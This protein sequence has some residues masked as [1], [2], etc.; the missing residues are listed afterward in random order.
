VLLKDFDFELPKSSIALRPASPRDASRLLVID[1]GALDPFFDAQVRDLPRFLKAGDVMVFN[2]TKVLPAELNGFREPR[3]E[4]QAV[5][6]CLTLVEPLHN[7]EWKAL[8]R[9]ARRLR[10]GDLIVFEKDGDR[11]VIA[12]TKKS[13]EG[14]VFVKAGSGGTVE[15]IMEQH[16]VMPLPPYISRLRPAD[17]RDLADYQTFYAKSKGAIAAP[18]AGLHFTPHLMGRIAAQGVLTA[19]VTLHVGPGTFL[20]VKSEEIE[21]H[22]LHAEWCEVSEMSARTINECRSKGGR[23]IA[24][25]TTSLRLLESAALEDGSISPYEGFTSLF[26]KPGHRFRTAEL[27]LTNFHLPK[28]TLFMLVC[29]FSGTARM[30]KA[31]SHAVAAGYRFYSYGDACLLHRAAESR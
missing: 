11:S 4:G 16:G 20:P 22:R 12:V 25:G 10:E 23:L 27:L 9:P 1:P 5:E 17:Q 18:T 28:S 14:E 8:A 2:N 26:I 31:Y 29:A 15:A 21:E 30:K 3:G 13:A 19:F 6:T 7:G 24:V